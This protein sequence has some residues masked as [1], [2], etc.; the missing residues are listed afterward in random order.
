MG[1]GDT[2]NGALKGYGQG[3][4]GSGQPASGLSELHSQLKPGER[5][6]GSVA[7]QSGR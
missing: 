3:I 1:K 4:V 2:G 7:L 6:E 5:G